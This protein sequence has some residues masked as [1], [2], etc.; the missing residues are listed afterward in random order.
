MMV[1]PRPGLKVRTSRPQINKI[2]MMHTGRATKNQTPHDGSGF[3]CWSAIRFWGDAMGEAAPPM[4]EARAMPRSN[5]F[6]M[7]ESAGRLRRIGCL[8]SKST[9]EAERINSPG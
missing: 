6:V 2:E 4:L 1:V 8:V 3:I 5:A 7:L 9:T